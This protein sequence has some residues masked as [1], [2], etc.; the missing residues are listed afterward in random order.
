[1]IVLKIKNNF[2]M[3]VWFYSLKLWF[4]IILYIIILKIWEIIV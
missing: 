3:I 1:M 2:L 4:R